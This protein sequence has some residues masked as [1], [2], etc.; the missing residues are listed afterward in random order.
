MLDLSVDGAVRLPAG[1][2]RRLAAEL[3]RM[4]R[5]AARHDGR[6]DYEVSLRLV[7]DAQ[8][9]ALNRGYRGH[10]RPTDVLAFA[11]R[12]GPAAA[13]HAALLGD[14]V[15][16]VDTARRQARRGLY[17]ELLHLASH[18]LCH[19]LGYDHR[20]DAQEAAMNARAAALRAE[21]SRR[22]RIRAA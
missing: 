10:D 4:I 11:Q 5:A 3:A 17:R 7:D 19:L 13:L 15:I 9:R 2:R 20:D 8:I 1:L 6:P 12:E 18:G 22:G 21:A 14:I 16:S